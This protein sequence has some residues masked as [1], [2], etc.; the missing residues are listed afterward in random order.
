MKLNRQIF[1]LRVRGGLFAFLQA[2]ACRER[3]RVRHDL[4]AASRPSHDAAMRPALRAHWTLDPHSHLPA[5]RWDMAA[6]ERERSDFP[7]AA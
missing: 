4:I 3:V 5:C 6:G 1:P 7:C 2:P